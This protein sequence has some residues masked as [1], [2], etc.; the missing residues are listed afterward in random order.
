MDT[1]NKLNKYLK[2]KGM[3]NSMFRPQGTLKKTI[4]NYTINQHLQLCYMVEKIGPLK[5][6]KQEE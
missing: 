1:D 3:I 6:Q 2:I 5:Q 4:I